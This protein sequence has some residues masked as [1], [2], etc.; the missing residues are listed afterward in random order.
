ME[1]HVP[2]ITGIETSYEGLE[3]IGWLSNLCSMDA[4]RD[5]CNIL[6]LLSIPL[7]HLNYICPCKI[8]A[9]ENLKKTHEKNSCPERDCFLLVSPEKQ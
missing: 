2:N 7:K 9:R 5:F 3:G 4:S 8:E 6:N 1:G